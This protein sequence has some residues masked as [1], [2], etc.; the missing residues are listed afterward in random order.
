MDPKH[1]PGKVETRQVY[2]VSLQQNRNDAKITPA[3]FENIVTKNKNVCPPTYL[4]LMSFDPW[5]SVSFHH[6]L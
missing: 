6:Q 4:W 2:G 3:L 5:H 1:V